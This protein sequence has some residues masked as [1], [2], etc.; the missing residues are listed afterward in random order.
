MSEE[1][2][3]ATGSLL[4]DEESDNATKFGFDDYSVALASIITSK[5]LQTP[6]TIAIHGDWGSGKTSLMKTVARKL[7]SPIDKCARVKTIWFNAWEFE[8]LSVPLWTIFL[9]RVIIEL[10]E[11]TQNEGLKSKIE[12][13]GE[14]VLALS[15]N[16]LLRKV[17]G[18]TLKEVQEIK[19]NVWTDI[20]RI[21]SLKEELSSSIENALKQDRQ[22]RERLVIFIDDLDRCL[23]GQAIEI[24][25]SIKLFL[26][27]K[28][29]V[30]IIGVDKEQIRKAFERQFGEKEGPSGLF[31]VE[32]FI[33][34]QFDLPR[35]TPVEV[36]DFL[37]EHASE[38]LKKSP[39]TI[40]LISRFIEPNPR[41]IKRW[42][43]SVSFLEKLFRIKQEKL[44]TKYPTEIDLSIVS[45]WLFL[46]SFFPDFATFIESD[47]PLL[48]I[49]I[50]VAKGR[51]SEEDKKKM[52]DFK[53]DKRLAEFLSL[54]KTD[55]DENQ[56][57]EVVYLSRLTP[58]VSERTLTGEDVKMMFPDD[59]KNLLSFEEKDDYITIKPIQFLGSENF[60]KIA[61]TVRGIGGE[62]VS[63]GRDSHFRVFKRK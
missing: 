50:R 63:A 19:E 51:G 35:K 45:I 15:T 56:L 22:K 38:Q 26:S 30:F 27:C 5:S 20:K 1:A 2:K 46:K 31:Y 57:R 7:E 12:A 29:C 21:N 49:A 16:I 55:Y 34:L 39:K 37:R 11:I 42:I 24:F 33:Q 61:T 44:L 28:N 18:I 62:Y 9:N 8:K 58:T 52:E 43:N 32:K 47:L 3:I 41:K 23:P 36:E 14:G 13:V 59:L 54:L 17:V 48:N 60:A 40:E 6:F 10:Q 53:I 4:P 25:E